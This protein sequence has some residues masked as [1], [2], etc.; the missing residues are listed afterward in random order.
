MRT[1]EH[2]APAGETVVSGERALAKLDVAAWCV[3]NACHLANAIRIDHFH[4]LVQQ[5]LYR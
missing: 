3:V 2:D 4:R 1:I 5:G